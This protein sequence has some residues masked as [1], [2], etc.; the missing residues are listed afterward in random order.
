MGIKFQTRAQ[1]ECY[2][3]V[4]AY[5]TKTFGSLF[6]A[7]DA[8]PTFALVLGSAMVTV[9]VLP[10]GQDDAVVM[11][12]SYVIFG[13]ELTRELLH[14]LL[15]ENFDFRFGAFGID[16]DGDIFF[17]HNIVGSTLDENELRASVLAVVSTAD[18]YDDKIQQ[19]FGGMRA[20]DR[21]K[22]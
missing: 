8:L 4:H 7:H 2:K 3:K 14:Y 9:T 12:R 17:G 5:M 21:A 11:V 15:L 16:K 13:A 20:I 6:K 22:L 19:R 10:W 18:E 1:E